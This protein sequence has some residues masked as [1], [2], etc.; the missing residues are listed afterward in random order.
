MKQG[1]NPDIGSMAPSYCDLVSCLNLYNDYKVAL[2]FN[3]FVYQIGIGYRA[4]FALQPTMRKIRLIIWIG[5][6][7]D[8][9][10]T[11]F[12]QLSSYCLMNDSIIQ[13]G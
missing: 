7:R 2:T 13:S 10:S 8:S 1:F 3:I 12:G 4:K 6:V 9:Y 11:N 5:L